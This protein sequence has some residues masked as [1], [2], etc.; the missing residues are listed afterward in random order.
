MSGIHNRL[1]GFRCIN[2]SLAFMALVGAF[3]VGAS[4]EAAMYSGTGM[5]DSKEVSATAEFS[6]D[7]DILTILLTHTGT[8]SD[9]TPAQVLTDVSFNVDGD[10]VFDVTDAA[11]M[12]LVAPGSTL[13]N[14]TNTDPTTDLSSEWGLATNASMPAAD[15][16]GSIVREFSFTAAALGGAD[17]NRFDDGTIGGPPPKLSGG[18]FGLIN[19]ESILNT[20]IV[21][22]DYHVVNSVQIIVKIVSGLTS[23]DQI[24]DVSFSFGS[25]HA[26]ISGPPTPPPTTPVPAPAAL[27]AGLALLGALLACR[28]F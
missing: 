15:G 17:N 4:A 14:G 9:Y 6:L 22:N 28:R 21:S 20:P 3:A 1:P 24:T 27:P 23:L 13:Y 10:A 16:S 7:G 5:V 19:V 12:V 8:R 18:D 11:S 26:S 25:T 2:R